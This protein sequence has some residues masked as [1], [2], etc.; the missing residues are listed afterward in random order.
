M[1]G[2][3]IFMSITVLLIPSVMIGFGNLFSS[4][5]TPS[6]INSTFGYRTARSMQNA[7]TWKFAH[8]YIGKLWNRIGFFMFTL[9]FAA[10]LSIMKSDI[11]LIAT[12]GTIITLVQIIILFCTIFPTEAALKRTFDEF[13]KYK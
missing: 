4:R 3:W 8:N 6:K 12:I 10:M 9:S 5:G 1:K 13:G 11:I 2:F 7:D